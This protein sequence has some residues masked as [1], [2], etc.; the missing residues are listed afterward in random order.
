MIPKRMAFFWVGR[1]SWLR[2]LTLSSFVRFNPDWE[3]VLYTADGGF[4]GSKHWKSDN[5]DD[6]SYE[7]PDYWEHIPKQVIIKKFVPPSVMSAAQM[8]DL[9]QWWYLGTEGGFYADM[10]ILWLRPFDETYKTCLSSNAVFCLEGT[11]L[12]I[13]LVGSTPNC[14]LFKAIYNGAEIES[15]ADYQHYGTNLL[16][17]VFEI[18]SGRQPHPG[19]RFLHLARRIYPN[20]QI[21]EI[22][23][24]TVYPF[25][26]DEAHKIF[27]RKLPV[28]NSSVGIHWFGGGPI[29]N[30]W[31][32]LLTE[33]SWTN[34]DNTLTARLN[35]IC[36]VEGNFNLSPTAVAS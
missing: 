7:G 27:E 15:N 10:D 6:S 25:I 35:R 33:D 17:R 23:Q 2:W 11:I 4:V 24:N 3:V 29:S 30:K 20:L 13:G 14:P 31:N 36:K 5:D 1:M 8:C 12:A 34:Y 22:P 28:P 21:E 32:R 18:D 19:K 16:Y 26:W 9:F